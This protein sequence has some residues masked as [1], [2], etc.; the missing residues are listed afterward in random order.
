MKPLFRRA[1]IALAACTLFA[2]AAQAG[3]LYTNDFGAVLPGY[4]P[5]DDSTF[6]F[7]LPFALNTAVGATTLGGVSNNGFLWLSGA[8]GT[9]Y[10]YAFAVDLDSRS[11]PT[12]DAA[13]H[14][15]VDGQKAIV[16]WA[17]MGLFG[18]DY[19]TKYT[20]QIVLDNDLHEAGLFFGNGFPS[21]F[22][23][24][25]GPYICPTGSGCGSYSTETVVNDPL[26]F[27][28]LTGARRSHF[29]SVPVPSSA[30]LAAAA[31][32]ALVTTRRGRR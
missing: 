7:T 15:R 28:L 31:L 23:S 20:F 32:G 16:T 12:A 1:S 18:P 25:V 11:S 13:V 24:V 2:G 21:S 9:E 6:G 26:Y 17:N 30:L 22:G 5:N 10:V 8:L 19:S 29:S 14:Y 4:V 3:A 27:D